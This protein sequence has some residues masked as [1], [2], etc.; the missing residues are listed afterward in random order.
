MPIWGDVF[1]QGIEECAPPILLAQYVRHRIHALRLY[2]ESIQEPPV[3]A[4]SVPPAV[5][6][7]TSHNSHAQVRPFPAHESP[8]VLA[9]TV[10]CAKSEI[11]G[12]FLP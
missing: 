3:S 9:P 12:D 4:P 7:P 11:V 5:E 6:F 2:L 10:S 1:V 8:R